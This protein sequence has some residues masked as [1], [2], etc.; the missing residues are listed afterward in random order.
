[1][2]SFAL[3]KLRLANEVGMDKPPSAGLRMGGEGL[4]ES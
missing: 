4:G 2:I 1:M 3:R